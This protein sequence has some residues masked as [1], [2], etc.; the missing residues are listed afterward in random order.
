VRSGDACRPRGGF[1]LVE[2]MVALVISGLVMATVFQILNGQT[3]AV[4]V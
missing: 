4:A 1:T 3:R 2:L